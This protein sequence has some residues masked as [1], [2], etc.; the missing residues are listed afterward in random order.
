MAHNIIDTVTPAVI[1]ADLA[2]S[3]LA[4]FFVAS[5][6]IGGILL[7]TLVGAVVEAYKQ[8]KTPLCK[9]TLT[10]ATEPV[11]TLKKGGSVE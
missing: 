1:V 11:V 2:D 10:P 4:S 3:F 6:C 5:A 7:S 8:G 9:E